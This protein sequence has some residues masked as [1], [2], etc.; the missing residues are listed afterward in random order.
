MKLSLHGRIGA[1]ALT[2]ALALSLA[3]CG[4]DDPTGSGATTDAPEQ[5][6][7]SGDLNGAGATSQEKAM[8][9]WRA[10]FQSANADVNIN[11]DPVG[12]GGGRTQFLDGSVEFAGSDS[13]LTAEEL[14][15]AAATCQAIDIPVYISPI[16]VVFNLEGVTELN[17]SAA[18]IAGI[19]D[20]KITTWDAPE[21][22][23]ENPDA[24]L[25]ATAITPV[26]RSDDSGT[27]KNFTDYLAKASGGAWAYE[28]DGNWPF[29][30]GESAQGTSGVIQTVQGGDGTIAY[31]DHSAVGTLGVASIQVGEEWV[32][33]SEEGAAAA[34]D[35]S[36]RDEEREEHDIVLKLDRETTEAGAYPL[37][38]VSYG[39]ACLQYDTAEKADLVKGFLSY[40]VS[41]EGQAAAQE[42]AGSAPLSDALRTDVQAAIDAISAAA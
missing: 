11:Y 31:A 24:T 18:T 41:A 17:L 5:S 13:A 1:I 16:A 40:V 12:S 36:P 6:T 26:H 20:N 25:P 7:L 4:S 38:L 23:A 15:T 3:A 30:G 34:V 21:I 29:E 19:F 27:T 37:I 28:A 39:V 32:A 14:E 42:A 10:G 33:P 8:D 2:G 35:A 22:A 9:A